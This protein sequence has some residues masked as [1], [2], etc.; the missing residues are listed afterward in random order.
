MQQ[1]T[2][3]FIQEIKIGAPWVWHCHLSQKKRH[4]L[5]ILPAYCEF[6][7]GTSTA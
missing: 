7:N 3:N 4:L 2:V 6:V 1:T 5:L